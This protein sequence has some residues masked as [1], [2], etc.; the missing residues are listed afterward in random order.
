MKSW[1]IVALLSECIVV[2]VLV[3]WVGRGR[4]EVPGTGTKDMLVWLHLLVLALSSFYLKPFSRRTD[5]SSGSQPCAERS[6]GSI[7]LVWKDEIV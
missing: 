6:E 2:V 1:I 3:A 4:A 5:V 7:Y